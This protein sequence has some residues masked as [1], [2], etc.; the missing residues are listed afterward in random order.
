MPVRGAKQ[1]RQNMARII[2]KIGGEMS[3]RAVY[4]SLII[5]DGNAALLTPVDTSNLIN[6][7]FIEVK[8]LPAGVQG[9]MGY[10]AE[11]AAAVHN[12]PGTYVGA[13]EPRASNDPS[14]GNMWEPNADP[15]FLPQGAE[16]AKA[17][18]DRVIKKRM[19]L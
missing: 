17:D 9:R 14:R 4:E 11:Y 10:T 5:I 1:V 18:N 7:R 6:S 8:K 13:N 3:E 12:S 19:K 2:G 15:E 16:N